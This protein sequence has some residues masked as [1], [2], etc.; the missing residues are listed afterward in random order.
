[1]WEPGAAVVAVVDRDQH[2]RRRR[3]KATTVAA[4]T[5]G[6]ATAR[7]RERVMHEQAER[8]EGD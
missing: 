8:R 7:G 6:R 5:S 3:T 2:S 4:S 1:M